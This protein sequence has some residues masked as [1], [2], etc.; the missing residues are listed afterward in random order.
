LRPLAVM[1]RTRNRPWHVDA[2]Q[3]HSPGRATRSRPNLVL[4][5]CDPKTDFSTCRRIGHVE[6]CWILRR[7]RV[8]PAQRDG[9]GGDCTRRH[10]ARGLALPLAA[11][12]GA[13][14]DAAGHSGRDPGVPGITP[15]VA[16]G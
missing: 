16:S 1:A 11:V 3:P 10:S 13:G 14:A 5:G 9:W 2:A 15:T 4:P 6:R 12:A 7:R 8:R